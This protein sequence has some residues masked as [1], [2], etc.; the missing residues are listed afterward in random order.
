[1]EP[2]SVPTPGR[3]DPRPVI[4]PTSPERYRVQFTVGQETHDRLRRLQTLL[5]REIPSGDP[6]AI[7][8]RATALLLA[9]VERTK[10]GHGAKAR[11]RPIRSG[12]DRIRR[13]GR[14]KPTAPV[15]SAVTTRDD[16]RCAFVSADGHRCTETEFLEF[17]HRDPAALDGGESET[18]IALHCRAHNEYEAEIFF[19]PYTPRR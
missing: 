13:G 17:H 7:F 8:D 4:L 19:G 1:M 10:L 15:R 16:A 9:Q 18:N 11:S 14:R 6:G 12:T 3:P 2:A 5:R